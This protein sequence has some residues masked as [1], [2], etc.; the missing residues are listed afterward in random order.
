MPTK[1]IVKQIFQNLKTEIDYKNTHLVTCK[2]C[3][4]EEPEILAHRHDGG[5][6][7][8]ECF[9]PRLKNTE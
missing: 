6:V 7:C 9:D 4:A 8:E 2:F 3:H 1:K 5:W